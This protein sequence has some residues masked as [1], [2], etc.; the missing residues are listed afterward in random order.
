M[1]YNSPSCVEL[2]EKSVIFVLISRND[3]AN[4]IMKSFVITIE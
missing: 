1:K 3:K 4:L 2:F